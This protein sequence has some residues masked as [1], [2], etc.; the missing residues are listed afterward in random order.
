M[1]SAYGQ[2]GGRIEW[3]STTQFDGVERFLP[4]ED[5]LH[6]AWPAPSGG[7]IG[8][9]PLERSASRSASRTPRSVT[10][11]RRFATATGR[12]WPSRS[13]ATRRRRCLEIASAPGSRDAQGPRQRGKT[14]FLGGDARPAAVAVTG[15]GRADRAA[16][17]QPR[18]GRDGLRPRRPADER[19]E[20]G[21]YSNVAELLKGLYRDV[22]PPWTTLIVDTFQAQLLDP[23]PAWLDRFV[24]VRLRR[25]AQGRAARPRRDAP[26]R[27]RGRPDH[28]QRGAAIL[29]LPPDGD[30]TDKTN[31]ANQLTANLNNQGAIGAQPGPRRRHRY[32]NAGRR[33]G[34]LTSIAPR[35]VIRVGG[36]MAEEPT[37]GHRRPREGQG[38]GEGQEPEDQRVPYERFQQ[39]NT[40]AKEAA[41]EGRRPREAAR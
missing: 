36:H 28:S 39:A 9:S 27:G 19:P 30:P 26:S 31:P 11:P 17:A 24:R 3:W 16:Q 2:Q 41:R 40:K 35:S 32:R 10:R 8:V 20:H 29:N 37:P 25:E 4:V 21:T 7:E 34:G 12:A 1:V 38:T 15:R 14:M 6:F 23:E 22:V 13:Q 5:T 18:R 33:T